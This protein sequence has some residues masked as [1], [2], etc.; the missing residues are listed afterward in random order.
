MIL[1]LCAEFYLIKAKLEKAN[2][3]CHEVSAKSFIFSQ[4][5][6]GD[7]FQS[8]AF[9]LVFV[10]INESHHLRGSTKNDAAR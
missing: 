1:R 7:I 2:P 8:V 6:A 5:A 10:G 3:T 9:E 4:D